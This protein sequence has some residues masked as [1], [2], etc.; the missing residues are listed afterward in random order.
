MSSRLV[1]SPSGRVVA[2]EITTPTTGLEVGRRLRVVG[3]EIDDTGCRFTGEPGGRPP[4]PEEATG[5]GR[6]VGTH[7]RLCAEEEKRHALALVDA[8][9]SLAAVGRELGV[10]SA[11]VG[12]WVRSR[13]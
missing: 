11:T 1:R 12:G 2:V 5:A 10:S 3:N 7:R 4:L 6:R 9:H 8:G 13:R